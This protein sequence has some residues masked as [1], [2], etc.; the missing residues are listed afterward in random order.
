MNQPNKVYTRS[1]C[2]AGCKCETCHDG[3]H[4]TR[5]IECVYCQLAWVNKGQYSEDFL[6][7]H[8]YIKHQETYPPKLSINKEALILN[9]IKQI[10]N[11]D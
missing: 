4:T 8:T 7:K 6:S 2:E 9:K 10:L 5:V 11:E 3:N 1:Y